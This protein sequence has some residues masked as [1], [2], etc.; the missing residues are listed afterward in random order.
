VGDVGEDG[1]SGEFELGGDLA[2]WGDVFDAGCGGEGGEGGAGDAG[3]EG[4]DKA[5][6]GD[7]AVG[8]AVD[9][10]G[11]REGGGLA[12]GAGAGFEFLKLD[13]HVDGLVFCDVWVRA[14]AA[15]SRGSTPARA[16]PL[17]LALS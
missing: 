17:C 11:R 3:G 5:E 13:D 14:G 9:A 16:I 8:A 15:V 1:G 7:G 2:I 12:P 4:A 10:G 6:F